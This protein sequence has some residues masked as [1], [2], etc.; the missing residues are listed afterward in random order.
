[1]SDLAFYNPV[2]EITETVFFFILLTWRMELQ[3]GD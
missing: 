2:R 3:V 1:M